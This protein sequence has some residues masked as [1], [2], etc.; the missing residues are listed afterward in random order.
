MATNV[1]KIKMSSSD[2][3]AKGN[4]GSG[5]GKSRNEQNEKFYIDSDNVIFV[6]V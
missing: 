5:E 4:E 6:R 3:Y 1:I 2:I